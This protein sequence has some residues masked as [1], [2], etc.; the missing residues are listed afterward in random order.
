[1]RR[2]LQDWLDSRRYGS[3]VMLKRFALALSGQAVELFGSGAPNITMTTTAAVTAG[4]LVEITGDRGVGPAGAN[5]LKVLGVAKQTGSA[6]GDKPAIATGGVW[7]L[8]ASGAI[9]AGDHVKAGALGV[10]VAVAADGDPRLITGIALAA[11][12]DATDGPVLLRGLS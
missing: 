1:M 8:R 2:R 4:R 6:V 10:V 3:R 7:M 11:I 5:S 9:A 12:V